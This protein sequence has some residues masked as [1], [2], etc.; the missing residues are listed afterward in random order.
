MNSKGQAAMEFLMTY[1]WAIFV[2]LAAIGALAYFGVLSP[3]KFL[4]D[5]CTA[6][7]PFSCTEYKIQ[8]TATDN[9]MLMI[10]NGG[11]D[12]QQ[13]TVDLSCNDGT[14]A[15]ALTTFPVAV[16]RGEQVNATFT[17]ATAPVTGQSWKSNFTMSYTASGEDV[18][19]Q[20]TGS[21]IVRAE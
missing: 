3:D 10:N 18:S 20:S 6:D 15:T 2:V 16:M 13:L 1:G 19:H 14:A 21:I 9:V 12:L 4:P 8:G 5:K 7:A 11:N 17:C